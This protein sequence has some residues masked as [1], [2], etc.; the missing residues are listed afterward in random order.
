MSQDRLGWCKL[1]H[2]VFRTT[3]KNTYFHFTHV[4]PKAQ[5]G[6]VSQVWGP[7]RIGEPG[8]RVCI[9]WWWKFKPM[10][11]LLPTSRKLCSTI[12]SF[13]SNPSPSSLSVQLFSFH[14]YAVIKRRQG[15]SFA[16]GCLAPY[17][18][19][20]SLSHLPAIILSS[21]DRVMAPGRGLFHQSSQLL[22]SFMRLLRPRLPSRSP[23]RI[24]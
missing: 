14:G 16:P 9:P 13:L 12:F 6:Q 21:R 2:V 10:S 1:N 20:R 19:C 8:S 17:G 4:E 24:S 5:R 15:L 3:L 23:P 7:G 22:M 11:G 18:G